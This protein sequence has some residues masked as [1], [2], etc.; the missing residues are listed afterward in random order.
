MFLGFI[1]LSLPL[2][3]ERL[4]ALGDPLL[5][6][7]AREVLEADASLLQVLQGGGPFSRVVRFHDRH[8]P[9]GLQHVPKN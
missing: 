1:H 6:A 4:D 3:D 2:G 8:K 7:E 9:P 5:D